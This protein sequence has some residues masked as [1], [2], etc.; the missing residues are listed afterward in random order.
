[1]VGTSTSTTAQ[2]K[3]IIHLGVQK[4]GSTSLHRFLG[5]NA[6]ALSDCLV[7]RTPVA[8]TPMRPL[9]RA[10]I[11]Y[12]LNCNSANEARLSD[13][14]A[15]VRDG[16]P[17]DGRAV[18]ISH[19]NLAGAMPGNGGEIRLYPSLP[20]IIAVLDRVFAPLLPVYV[21]Y[22][23]PMKAWKASVW[24]QAVRT[25]GYG[26][27]YPRFL[28]ETRDLTGWDDLISR[29]QVAAPGRLHHF[30]LKAEP[31]WMRPGRQLMAL[32]GI[33]A[34]RYAALKPLAKPSMQRLNSGSTEFIRQV[35]NLSFSSSARDK[36]AELVARNQNLFNAEFRPE[37]TPQ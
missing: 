18:L 5:Q 35:N 16:L 19:E 22:T 32:A 36:M 33:H 34:E 17:Q 12:S 10:A 25:D 15:V 3:L 11:A 37:G 27:D 8:G 4:T 30:D 29:L 9:G 21:V 24:A 23:R 14:I 28:E 1:M 7:I 31:E 13:A 20:R 2:Q 26:R 6:T